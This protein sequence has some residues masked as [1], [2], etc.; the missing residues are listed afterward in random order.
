MYNLVTNIAGRLLVFGDASFLGGFSVG[1]EIHSLGVNATDS[2]RPWSLVVTG[3]LTWTSGGL[4]PEGN[5]N[6]FPATEEGMFV[7]GTTTAPSYLATRQTGGPCSVRRVV[8]EFL[9]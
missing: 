9:S 8:Y 5:N 7:G 6:P 1:Y 3:N 4:Y 2:V